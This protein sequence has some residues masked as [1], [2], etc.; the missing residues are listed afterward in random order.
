MQ[1]T[2]VHP[3]IYHPAFGLKA[4]GNPVTR[5]ARQWIEEALRA[6]RQ[7]GAEMII[8]GCSELSL[9]I[10]EPALFNMPMID[11][12]TILARALIREVAPEKLKTHQAFESVRGAAPRE[13]STE[14]PA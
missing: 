5:E 3:A 6:L 14:A 9:A 13:V 11:P 4:Q 2:L 7:D 8:L 12:T 1:E 10:T